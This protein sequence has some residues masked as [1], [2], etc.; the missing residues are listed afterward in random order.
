MS[1]PREKLASSLAVLKEKQ[2]GGTRVFRTT[3]FSRTARERLVKHGFLQAALKGWLISSSP[4]PAQGDTTPWFASFWEFC[5]R[6]CTFRFEDDWHLSPQLSLDLHAEKS[7]IPK[8]VVVFSTRAQNNRISLPHDTSLYA[9]KQQSN[10]PETDL[11]TLRGLR[12]FRPEAA[13]IRVPPSYYRLSPTE[14]EVVLSGIQEPSVL[15]H[16]LLEGGHSTVAGRLAGA[17]RR[18]LRPEIADEIRSAMRAAGHDV[19]ESDPFD[20]DGEMAPFLHTPTPPIA[21]RLLR[22]WASGRQAVLDT[23]GGPPEAPPDPKTYLA[24]IDDIYRHDAYH[25]LSIEGYRVTPELLARVASGDWDPDEDAA[26]RED[27]NALAARGYYQAFRLVRD[28]VARSYAQND[29]SMIRLE[30]RGWYRELFAP[31]VAAGLLDAPTLAGY[32]T[33]PVYLRGSRH[34]PPRWEILRHAMPTV[35][36]LIEEEPEPAVRAVL[37][38]WLMGYVHPFPDGNGRVARFVMNALFAT[39]GYPWTVIRAQDREDYLESL[40]QAS[41]GDDLRPFAAF[42][43][44]Q[45]EMSAS[46]TLG[47]AT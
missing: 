4:N 1:K 14:A 16:H 33:I 11:M 28:T 44:S 18:L 23:I 20:S 22:L 45:M 9:V 24:A 13:L 43:N 30:H 36:D 7:K 34:M 39:A 17:Y 32:R 10:P 29:P 25:S 26:H 8:Q 19:R 6:Y 5:S 35:F 40:E 2:S 21:G 12:V 42:V 41:V 3:E 37:G 47:F 27:S 38:H 31:H 15:L 46:M